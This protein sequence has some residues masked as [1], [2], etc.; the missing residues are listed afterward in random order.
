VLD[1]ASRFEK[2]PSDKEMMALVDEFDMQQI[3]QPAPRARAQ[4]KGPHTWGGQAS[5]ALG[6]LIRD[7]FFKHP[8]RRTLEHVVKALES[9]GLLT[10]GKEDNISSILAGRV[11]KGVLKKSN[12]SNG[13]IYWT[14]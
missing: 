13:W 8:N 3:F 6:G 1:A 14:E 11:R 5:Q 9:K 2:L 10:K 7:G 4:G 12:V